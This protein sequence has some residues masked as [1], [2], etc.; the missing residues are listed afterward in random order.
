MLRFPFNLLL[1][2]GCLVAIL[3]CGGSV[4]PAALPVLSPV[5][6]SAVQLDLSGLSTRLV[7]PDATAEAQPVVPVVL[8]ADSVAGSTPLPTRLP[9]LAY[10]ESSA[11]CE[12]EFRRRIV[13]YDG[14]AGF[15][16]ELVSRL[17]EDFVRDAAFCAAE[18]WDP[19]FSLEPVCTGLDVAGHRVPTAL[20]SD[21]GS[22]PGDL[23]PTARDDFGNVLVHFVRMPFAFHPGCWFYDAGSELWAW[24]L[25]DGT[26]GFDR[27]VHS[28]CGDELRRLLRGS[29]RVEAVNV[30]FLR[31]Q[32]IESYPLDCKESAWSLYPSI[33][34]HPDCG[35]QS[36]TGVFSDGS[37][38]VN[39]LPGYLAYDQAV[40]WY[41]EEEVALWRYFYSPVE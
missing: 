33:T 30:V 4:E 16:G 28:G 13:Q 3:G 31:E 11:G 6:E 29:E 18:Q 35:V 22:G 39:W 14:P 8:V 17:S 32:V 19:V 10:L 24:Q 20:L 2:A 25:G 9:R 27:V 36:L 1:A 15:G 37:I 21:G 5:E 34:A 23:G 26:E 7:I 38:I 12:A 40:C 41:W